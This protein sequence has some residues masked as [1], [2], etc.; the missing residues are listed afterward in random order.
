MQY[1][2]NGEDVAGIV[3]KGITVPLKRAGKVSAQA[4]FDTMLCRW[5][6]AWVAG[7]KAGLKLYGPPFDGTHR[8]PERSRPAAEGDLIFQTAAV[9]GWA[10]DGTLAEVRDNPYVPLPKEWTHWRGLY[11]QGDDIVLSYTVQGTGV[12]EKA[13]YKN[14]NGIDWFERVLEI[15]PSKGPLTM[16]VCDAP[17][18]AN[19]RED[20][21]EFEDDK[22]ATIVL[23][24]SP[25]GEAHL[26]SWQRIGNE[27]CVEIPPLEK[28]SHFAIRI[29]HGPVAQKPD[30]G[31]WEA[32]AGARTPLQ[33][34]SLL[35]HGGPGH[36]PQPIVTAGKVGN[37]GAAYEVDSLTLPNENPWKAWMRPGGFDF[38]ADEKSAALCTWSGDVWSVSGI[39]ETLEKLVWRRI[40]TGLFQP[41]GLKIVDNE[42]YVLGRD[43]ITRLHDLNGDG[44]T[45]F[46]ENFN[47]DVSCTPNFHEFCTDLHTD[48]AGNFYFVKG[49]PLL[50]T[51]KWDP[52]GPHNGCLLRVSKDGSKLETVATGLRAPNGCGVGPNGELTT[53][54]NEGIWTPVCRIN[55]VSQPGMFLGAVGMDHHKTRPTTYDAPLCW[56][57]W[58]MDN[59]AAGQVW[60]PANFGPLSGSLL[61]LSYGKCAVFQVLKEEVNSIAQAG[62][63]KLPWK[64][65][66]SCMRARVNGDALY[67]AGLRGWQTTAARDGAFHRVRYTGLP[68]EGLAAL[69]VKHGALELTF[70]TALD[71]VSATDPGNY[72]VE[73]WNYR[74]TESYG[75][76][77][78]SATD[79]KK[80]VGKKGELKGE[81]VEIGAITL[82]TDCKTVRL[83]APNLQPVMQMVTRARIKTAAGRDLSLELAQT[84]NAVPAR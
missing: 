35:T 31:A 76:D 82:S 68:S 49:G 61:H 63:V 48:A 67:I 66:S 30:R 2:K 43:Q 77:L 26:L 7:E 38:F 75:S 27:L 11:V 65:E 50:G 79:P 53:G 36:Y 32:A 40:A 12:L 81:L 17:P 23:W 19:A 62:I 56:I 54:D 14:G 16:V 47:N 4:C 22:N 69:H 52:A 20:V 1:A 64:F 73:Q 84:I 10:K 51:A 28:T 72:D 6:G 41:L 15:E 9:P 21:A 8:P 13:A 74:W 71:P 29:W 33:E 25:H 44:E 18:N 60:A 58:S 46:Y 70:N 80:V 42:V 34:L 3:T 24:D 55:W 83:T 78:Y 57:P 39:D 5:A 45:D 59:S 37:T